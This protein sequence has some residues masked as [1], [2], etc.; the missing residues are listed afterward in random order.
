MWPCCLNLNKPSVA[1]TWPCL[2]SGLINVIFRNGFESIIWIARGSISH[3]A[4]WNKNLF[5][6]YLWRSRKATLRIRVELKWEVLKRKMILVWTSGRK[7]L[8]SYWRVS[9]VWHTALRRSLRDVVIVLTPI[10][11]I[12]FCC[13]TRKTWKTALQGLNVRTTENYR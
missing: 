2:R 6:W 11:L 5:S 1:L 12:Y 10:V 4:S 13:K 9:T 7:T 8:V 3:I